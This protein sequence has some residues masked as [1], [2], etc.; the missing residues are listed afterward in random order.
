[1]SRKAYRKRKR[2]FKTPDKDFSLLKR[3]QQSIHKMIMD[4]IIGNKPESILKGV[5]R[6]FHLYESL[7]R[8][9]KPLMLYTLENEMQ[10]KIYGIQKDNNDLHDVLYSD[11]IDFDYCPSGSNN[12]DIICKNIYEY[13]RYIKIPICIYDEYYYDDRIKIHVVYD[14]ELKSIYIIPNYPSYGDLIE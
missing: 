10:I 14:K 3:Y 6:L 9:M 1:M 5:V 11:N 12:K 7:P 13:I 8:K 4:C 2:S